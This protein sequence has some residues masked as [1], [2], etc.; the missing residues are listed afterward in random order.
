MDVSHI[1]DPLN[2]AQREAVTAPAGPLLVLAGA[3]SGKTRVLVHRIA[4][5]IEVERVSPYGILAVTFTNKAA[6]EMRGRIEQLLGVPA[7]GMWV[8]TFH[9]LAHRLLRRHWQDVGLPE[10]FQILDADDQ[11]RVVKRVVR[12]LELDEARWPPRQLQWYINGRKDEGL[13]PQHIEPNDDPFERTQLRVYEAYEELCRR[14]GMVDFAELL[15]RAHELWLQRPEILDHYRQR[16]GHLLVDEFQDTNAI[17][18]AWLRLLAGS[19]GRLFA[20]GDDDQSI[21]GWRG[22]R[23]E[24]LQR[25]SQDFAGSRLV[26]L[27]QNYRS[28]ATIL[29]AANA[30]IA[31]NQGRLGKQLWTEGEEGDPI[32]LYNAFNEYDEA[33]F[34]VER[35]EQAVAEGRARSEIAILYRSNAQS[36]VFEEQLM[37]RQIPYRV[38][39][40][41]RFFERAEIK[42]ALGYLRL[43]SNPHDDASFERVVNQPPRGIGERTLGTV[44]EQARQRGCSLWQATEAVIGEGLLNARAS[45]ALRAF[46]ELIREQAA[47]LTDLPLEEQ[48]EQVIAASRLVEHYRKEKGER[49]QTR[50]ENLQ[51]L[52]NAARH[53]DPEADEATRDMARL[54]AFLAHAALEAGEG[55][56]EAWE[57]CVQLM[58]LHSAKGLEFP[59][60]FMAGM[61]EGLFPHQMSIEEPGRLE[62]ERRL[63]Y[64]GMTRARQQLVMSCA[65]RRRLHGSESYAL[66]SRFLR[67]IP[68]ELIEE[69]RPQV[70]VRRPLSAAGGS[71]GLREAPP[72]AAGGSL[73]LGQ[74]VRHPKFGEGVVL[75]YEGQGA[76]ARVQVNFSQAGAKWLVVAYANLEMA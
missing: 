32:Q 28:T 42:D 76:H 11:L 41:L 26:R 1:L 51:E 64:V 6:K 54:D 33:R 63:C 68:G 58:T 43:A 40:G 27:E 74:Q 25:F 34:V 15:L 16:F 69:I 50:I 73:Q 5:L 30:L 38:Y 20:V 61:E 48:V 44:R 17:Q 23:V 52:V 45:N 39:G 24:N 9:G 67:E 18:Y 70:S 71:S 47:G 2:D 56:A 8:G 12:A 14:G 22:A 75:N 21:Y 53:F 7:G 31:H 35:I 29:N 62:E 13:R 59:L 60:V 3:G 72:Q 57:D 55:Q 37:Q 19:H 65:E 49:G 66:P 4:W 10:S 46:L 36:R